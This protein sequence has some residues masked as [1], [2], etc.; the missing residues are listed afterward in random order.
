MH[1]KPHLATIGNERISNMPHDFEGQHW[2]ENREAL[3]DGVARLFASIITGL[4]RLH[5]LTFDA[6]W[7]EKCDE[8]ECVDL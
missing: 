6:P 1:A 5:A 2:A 3:S 7:K 8:R 4:D